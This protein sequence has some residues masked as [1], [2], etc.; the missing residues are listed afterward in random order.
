MA[1]REHGYRHYDGPLTPGWSRFLVLPRYA[2]LE[3]FR[4]RAFVGFLVF[5]WMWSF[6]LASGLYLYHNL[7]TALPALAAEFDPRELFPIDARVFLGWFMVPTGVVFGFVVA[8]I[9]GP[10]LISADLAN[11]ALPLYLSRPLGRWE[12]LA[13]K[14]CVLAIV[15]SAITWVPGLMLFALQSYYA[16]WEWFTGNLRIAFAVFA[17]AWVWIALLGLIALAISAF[18]RWRTLARAALFGT[19]VL[20]F[21]MA[22]TINAMFDTRWGSLIDLPELVRT[23]WTGLF[24]IESGHAI[25]F[26]AASGSLAAIAGTCVA[27][28]QT[29]VRAYR[30]VR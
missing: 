2:Y 25:P 29:R 19:F 26:W 18:V 1:V 24:G 5:C 21:A 22:R 15:L 13:G 27:L 12:Y 20:S 7:S 16:G 6:S 11:N 4:S 17:G 30:V 8:L 3:V 14:F 10:A 9:L 23:V 28:L